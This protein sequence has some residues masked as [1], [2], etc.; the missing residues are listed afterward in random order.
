MGRR[1]DRFAARRAPAASRRIGL[2][3]RVT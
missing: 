2:R 1:D 3:L